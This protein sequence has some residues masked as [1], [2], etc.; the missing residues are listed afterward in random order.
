M[1]V[2]FVHVGKNHLSQHSQYSSLVLV[3]GF[4]VG[5]ISSYFTYSY[6]TST[7]TNTHELQLP[8]VVV[9]IVGAVSMLL[10]WATETYA[11][12][13]RAAYR[14][15]NTFFY[16]VSVACPVVYFGLLITGTMTDTP[17]AP[18]SL[19][20]VR[21]DDQL[22]HV[23][24][25]GNIATSAAATMLMFTG[26]VVMWLYIAI[27][28]NEEMTVLHTP[29]KTTA[30]NTMHVI[31]LWSFV[32]HF[33]AQIGVACTIY[34][35][36]RT[37]IGE[38]NC[39]WLQGMR[40]GNALSISPVHDACTSYDEQLRETLTD[41]YLEC[42]YVE[43]A[44]ECPMLESYA[45]SVPL[46]EFRHTIVGRN[47]SVR[48]SLVLCGY[49]TTICVLWGLYLYV[50]ARVSTD[51]ATDTRTAKTTEGRIAERAYDVA[52]NHGTTHINTDDGMYLAAHLEHVLKRWDATCNAHEKSYPI[53]VHFLSATDKIVRSV[54]A[55]RLRQ[56][57]SFTIAFGFC[58]VGRVVAVFSLSLARGGVVRA[59]WSQALPE[60]VN[61]TS[62][63]NTLS[64]LLN[65]AV[66]LEVL[67]WLCLLTPLVAAHWYGYKRNSE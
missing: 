44:E 55:T 24:A 8:C 34:V 39:Y 45:L 27:V 1:S 57:L 49:F 9:A 43:K 35:I 16:A 15:V 25:A 58:C 11:G 59:N 50:H 36:L 22:N 40:I 29:K 26:T 41:A 33:V 3:S 65:V 46:V 42:A 38:P 14:I 51:D 47:F 30:Q 64:D 20:S 48:H 13:L 37:Y 32:L 61:L 67:C 54:N 62:K 31:C 66:A 4:V 23:L 7:R 18:C 6:G 63:V 2:D 19:E 21:N 10:C 5:G 53:S 52:Q 28:G 17:L 60:C 56:A 12:A